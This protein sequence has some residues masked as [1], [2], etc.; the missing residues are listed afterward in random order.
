[1]AL[2]ALDEQ[3]LAAPR[4]RPPCAPP[5]AAFGSAG[6]TEAA[7]PAAPWP[8]P[9]AAVFADHTYLPPGLVPAAEGLQ[10]LAAQGVDL[11]LARAHNARRAAA[12]TANRSEDKDEDED[13]DE[14]EDGNLSANP[15]HDFDE[16][17]ATQRLAEVVLG[18]RRAFAALGAALEAAAG[19]RSATAAASRS[20]S[21]P[22]ETECSRQG[23]ADLRGVLLP[24]ALELGALAGSPR[25]GRAPGAALARS[26]QPQ[27]LA[28]EPWQRVLPA[29]T[30]R[31]LAAA[32]APA[33]GAAPGASC[34]TLIDA[35]LAAALLAAASDRGSR[36]DAAAWD[37]EVRRWL[38]ADAPALLL[39]AH[40]LQPGPARGLSGELAARSVG[41]HRRRAGGVGAGRLPG[42]ATRDGGRAGGAAG[43]VARV[44]T[45]GFEQGSP[46]GLC[47]PPGALGGRP[48]G[49]KRWN[50]LRIFI[51][52]NCTLKA[53]HSGWQNLDPAE[54]VF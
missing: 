31:A 33:P 36:S 37:A 35:P 1:M 16:G 40:A 47:D 32:A 3:L 34:L 43:L 8:Y 2:H 5:A 6:A 9:R 28:H 7:L 15:A 41:E 17:V 29:L 10:L 50:R 45:P 18:L 13:E 19:P 39:A 54:R 26:L 46:R 27:H 52:Q 53:S 48:G 51:V 12:R 42:R 22:P 14:D 11:L 38:L 25:L 23:A 20:G 49:V 44:A 30:R 24:L 4:W 21:P